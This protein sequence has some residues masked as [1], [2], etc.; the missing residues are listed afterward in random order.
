MN[1]PFL[2]LGLERTFDLDESR[3]RR[4]YLARAAMMHPDTL[5]GALDGDADAS[6]AALNEAKRTL[7]DPERRANALLV[8]LGGAS[9]EGD[10]TL[11]PGFLMEV[12]ELRERVEEA[13]GSGDASARARVGRE[14]GEAR[15]AYIRRVGALFRGLGELDGV[16]GDERGAALRAIRVEL[17]AWRYIERLI[18]QLDPGY[19]PGRADFGRGASGS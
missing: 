19:D 2:V 15:E 16:G 18:E 14:A 11:A 4:A 3:I 12:M 17:N 8:L 10:R 6:S 5:E 13:L 7:E 9:A 1:D